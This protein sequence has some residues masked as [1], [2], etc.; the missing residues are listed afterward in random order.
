MTLANEETNSIPIDEANRA[1]LDNVKMQ[2]GPPGGHICNQYAECV[3]YVQLTRLTESYP[4]S[5]VPLAM[6]LL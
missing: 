4:G 2:V 3:V 6:V 1:I 5:V